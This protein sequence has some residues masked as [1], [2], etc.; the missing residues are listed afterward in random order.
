MYGMIYTYINNYWGVTCD[1]LSR[2]Q[3]FNFLFGM[4][5]ICPKGTSAFIWM[6]LKNCMQGCNDGPFHLNIKPK[7]PKDY[8]TASASAS[9]F[10]FICSPCSVFGVT[11]FWGLRRWREEGLLVGLLGMLLGFS[12]LIHSLSGFTL[13][14]CLSA[15]LFTT[16]WSLNV[17]MNRKTGPED[18]VIKVLYCG[19]DHTDLH[20]MRNEVHSTNYPLVP[21]S[22]P[23]SSSLSHILLTSSCIKRIQKIQKKNHHIAYRSL[24]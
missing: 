3:Q 19:M 16:G 17:Y 9:A 1:P 5:R 22:A 15:A 7:P 18:V 20:Q 24:Y 6:P 10:F 23:I 14:F 12:L 4:E 11:W 8:T 2:H 13:S 21:G